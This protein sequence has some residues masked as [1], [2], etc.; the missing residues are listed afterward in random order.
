MPFGT[1]NDVKGCGG[2]VERIPSQW[3]LF[4]PLPLPWGPPTTRVTPP[5]VHL[6]PGGPTRIALTVICSPVACARGSLYSEK[7]KRRTKTIASTNDPRWN[8]TFIY[9]SVRRAE[10]KVR[11]LEVT[12]WDYVRYGA[13]DFLGE[14]SDN[15]DC[16]YA[17]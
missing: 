15:F 10:L 4:H 17:R 12:V 9:S 11:V 16:F 6:Q 7:S 2:E 1:S 8:Q 13:N 14:V 5:A 3:R